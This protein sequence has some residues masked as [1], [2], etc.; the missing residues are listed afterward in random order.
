MS[1]MQRSFRVVFQALLMVMLVINT[2]APTV[3]MA[4]SSG[5]ENKTEN[6]QISR[7]ENYY[8]APILAH[9]EPRMGRVTGDSDSATIKQ[10]DNSLLPVS[11]ETT[12]LSDLA[13]VS[14][15]NG[16]GPAEKDKS[17]GD[18]GA[19][20]GGIITLNGS[21]Y[22][23]GLGT[24][25]FSNIYYDLNAAYTLFISDI[26]L[27]D[28][29]NGCGAT[30]TV[31]FQVYV[32]GIKQFDS[33]TMGASSPTQ[34]VSVNVTGADEL[35]LYVT[36]GGAN[37]I[38]CDHADWADARLMSGEMADPDLSVITVPSD[39]IPAD[40]TSTAAIQVALKDQSGQAVPDHVV[41]LNISGTD[42]TF[43]GDSS[44]QT[45]DSGLATFL[46]KSIKPETKNITIIDETQGMELTSHPSVAFVPGSIVIANGDSLNLQAGSYEFDSIAI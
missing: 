5:V 21:T 10:N 32:D 45:D 24:H 29:V 36:D 26:G 28:E 19:G 6:R 9:P 8:Q 11:P 2:L 16:W 41:T 20:D 34:Q 23:K 12:Y 15:T 4:R 1:T 46:V 22:L 3:A 17:N 25:A 39:S 37:G 35:R 14:A 30:G 40:G 13:W 38:T 18:S 42:N 27:D 7:K 31:G 43:V 44:I 33:V